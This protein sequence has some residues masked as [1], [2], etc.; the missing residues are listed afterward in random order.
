MGKYPLRTKIV[1]DNKSKK[2][3]RREKKNKRKKEEIVVPHASAKTKKV[4]CNSIVYLIS[5]M[6][7]IT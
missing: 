4:V 7:K 3:Q 6:Q 1:L 2:T 5:S